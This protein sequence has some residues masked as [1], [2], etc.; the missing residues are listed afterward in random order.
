MRD[1][2]ADQARA[3]QATTLTQL[4]PIVREQVDALLSS[5][6]SEFDEFERFIV[7]NAG[8][9]E[10]LVLASTNTSIAFGNLSGIR[11]HSISV[12][13]VIPNAA[14]G[15]TYGEVLSIALSLKVSSLEGQTALK[16]RDGYDQHDLTVPRWG[17]LPVILIAPTVI[18]EAR[19]LMWST[20]SDAHSV[21]ER[22][23]YYQAVDLL[24][25]YLSSDWRASFAFALA[26]TGSKS[27]HQDR[28]YKLHG[29]TI[30]LEKEEGTYVAS[31]VDSPETLIPAFRPSWS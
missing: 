21:L 3:A 29:K 12:S 19:R 22:C 6:R 30:V 16:L 20:E 13:E 25:H 26:E 28:L 5:H 7:G 9:V 17:T 2:A 23:Y 24:R 18:A 1:A 14:N 8:L 10:S 4:G 31:L 11:I 15:A 27:P